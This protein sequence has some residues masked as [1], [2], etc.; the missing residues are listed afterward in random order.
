MAGCEVE[1]AY[2]FAVFECRFG[3]GRY[4]V[5]LVVGGVVVVGGVFGF[6]TVVFGVVED[7]ERSDG[8]TEGA[9]WAGGPDACRPHG[10]G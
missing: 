10:C 1:L 4:D 6:G 5:V 7:F 2:A 9:G 8:E 3:D